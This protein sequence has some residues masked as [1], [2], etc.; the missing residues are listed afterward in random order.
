M[1]IGVSAGCASFPP[2]PQVFTGA[3][4]GAD[5]VFR[6]T[7]TELT[8]SSITASRLFAKYEAA[9]GQVKTD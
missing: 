2:P 9:L 7:P 6:S 3:S 4:S 1:R 5:A 8:Q